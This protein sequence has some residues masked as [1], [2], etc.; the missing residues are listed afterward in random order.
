[1]WRAKEQYSV[2][3]IVCPFPRN[4][5]HLSCLLFFLSH[6]Y[7]RRY[8][9][10]AWEEKRTRGSNGVLYRAVFCAWHGIEAEAILDLF[11]TG[12]MEV[13]S[14]SGEGHLRLQFSLKAIDFKVYPGPRSHTPLN[15][16][17][18]RK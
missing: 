18:T 4:L 10:S 14:Q 5:R 8:P 1:M 16:V 12:F 9:K 2:Y 6:S 3:I 11:K 13:L 17:A 15:D 7:K